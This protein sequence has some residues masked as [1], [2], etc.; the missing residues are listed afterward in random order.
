MQWWVHPLWLI[1]HI[2]R[3]DKGPGEINR[4]V[5]QIFLL[6][7]LKEDPGSMFITAHPKH[8][9]SK[10]CKY[11]CVEWRSWSGQRECSDYLLT[12][13]LRIWPGWRHF[14]DK[15]EQIG[16][17][18]WNAFVSRRPAPEPEP[19]ICPHQDRNC[20]RLYSPCHAFGILVYVRHPR[21][22]NASSFRVLTCGCFWCL[23]ELWGEPAQRILPTY[24]L[25]SVL[26]FGTANTFGRKYPGWFDFS[27]L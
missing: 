12:E 9:N 24:F 10:L 25:N 2:F 26:P 7:W 15:K 19:Y 13:A 23:P 20:H 4:I 1:L 21:G 17:F 14:E 6:N 16:S 18:S 8:I 5:W 27:A 22:C 3:D 11:F